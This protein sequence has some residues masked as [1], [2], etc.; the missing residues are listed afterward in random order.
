M[1]LIRAGVEFSGGVLVYYVQ[2][3]GLDLYNYFEH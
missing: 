1:F 2:G 3:P